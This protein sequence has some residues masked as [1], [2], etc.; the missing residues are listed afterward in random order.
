MAKILL[1]DADLVLCQTLRAALEREGYDTL[2]A[3]DGVRGLEL[4]RD[5]LPDLV[6]LE[7]RLPG[8]DGFSICRI[9]RF[10]S[11]IPVMLLSVCEN[12]AD[13]ILGLDLGADDYVIKPF[14]M[15]ELLARVRARLRRNQRI[16]ERPQHESLT[17]DSL[18][19]DIGRHRVFYGDTEIELV[20]KEFEL[21]VCLMRNSGLALSREMLLQ[22]VW[23]EDFKHDPRTV[24]VHIR[25]LRTKVEPDPPNPR[26]IQTVRG[27]G[28]RFVE[29][30]RTQVVNHAP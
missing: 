29:G 2:V 23:G 12:E 19:V 5:T 30:V 28:Y 10:E 27:Q 26:Y 1:I 4:V 14:L 20:Q 17:F 7:A 18:H 3:N 24:D 11:D 6:I 25:W 16:I 22:H 9:V 21:L 15:G 13:R 8:I